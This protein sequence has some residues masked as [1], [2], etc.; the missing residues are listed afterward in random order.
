[1]FRCSFCL[2]SVRQMRGDRFVLFA[3]MSARYEIILIGNSRS[4]ERTPPGTMGHAQRAAFE[5]DSEGG[6]IK[7][8]EQGAG[9]SA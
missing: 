1:M 3:N 8:E 9:R 2:M 6:S 7:S 5:D 4:F